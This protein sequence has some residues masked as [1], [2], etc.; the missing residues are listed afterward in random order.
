ME[1]LAQQHQP[2]PRPATP[3]DVRATAFGASGPLGPPVLPLVEP[4]PELPPEPSSLLNPTEEFAP[5]KP[6]KAKIVTLKP[7]LPL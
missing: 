2:R 3:S 7:V 1:A 4:D 5:V 6:P